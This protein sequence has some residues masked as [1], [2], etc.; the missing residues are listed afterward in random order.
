LTNTAG[1]CAKRGIGR[2]LIHSKHYSNFAEPAVRVNEEDEMGKTA[3]NY[4]QGNLE[5]ESKAD[6]GSSQVHH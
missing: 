6:T 2:S 3:L 4:T 1:N 5:G